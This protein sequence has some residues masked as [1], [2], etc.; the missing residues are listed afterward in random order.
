LGI[1]NAMS[2]N[3]SE[4]P[5][6]SHKESTGT[7]AVLNRIL[8]AVEGGK[9]RGRLELA[10]AIILSLATLCSTWCGF[11][12]KQWGGVQSS[13]QAAADTAERQAAEDTIVGLQLRTFDGISL[14][15]YWRALRQ[16]DAEVHEGIFARMRPALQAAVKGA[17]EAGVLHDPKAVGPLQRPEYVLEVETNAAKLRVEAR[18]AQQAAREAGQVGGAYV[19]MTLAFASV[20]FFGGITGT[21]SQPRIRIGLGCVA[22][23]LFLAALATL[24]RLSINWG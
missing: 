10:M 4:P 13:S 12:A 21:F 18:E 9:R 5:H 3:P 16:K 15:E 14:L 24:V 20:L 2:P 8:A 17:L 19:L 11:Q 7:D 1:S 22:L 6:S 23:V